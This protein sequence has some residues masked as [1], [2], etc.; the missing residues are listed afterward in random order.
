M[1][2]TVNLNLGEECLVEDL[3]S[4]KIKI[5]K[6]PSHNPSIVNNIPIPTTNVNNLPSNKLSRLAVHPIS[7]YIKD[8]RLELSKANQ[9]K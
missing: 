1:N 8:S 4:A 7:Q 3:C 6:E 5:I 9:F 2:K